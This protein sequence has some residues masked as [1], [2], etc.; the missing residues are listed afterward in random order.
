MKRESWRQII[1]E[2]NDL[3]ETD[4]GEYSLDEILL[5]FRFEYSDQETEETMPR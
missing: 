3:P 1:E 2:Q 5:Q 4:T